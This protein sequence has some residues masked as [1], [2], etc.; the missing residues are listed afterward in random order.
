[1]LIPSIVMLPPVGA[2]IL[3]NNFESVLFPHPDAPMIA[4]LSPLFILKLKSVNTGSAAF[5]YLNDKELK[6]ISPYI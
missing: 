5:S 6:E 1:M 4:I 3:T 2:K